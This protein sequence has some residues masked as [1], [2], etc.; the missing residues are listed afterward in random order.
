MHYSLLLT[1]LTVALASSAVLP[2]PNHTAGEEEE[3][4]SLIQRNCYKDGE[5]WGAEYYYALDRAKELCNGPF[6][7]TFR[8]GE[9]RAK[10]FNLSDKKKADFS[11]VHISAGDRQIKY[12][13]CIDGL[14]KEIGRCEHG[15]KTSYVNWEYRCVVVVVVVCNIVLIIKTNVWSFSEPTPIPASAPRYIQS[16]ST[17]PCCVVGYKREIDLFVDFSIPM[18]TITIV[19][20]DGSIYPK[21]IA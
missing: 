19:E 9:Y 4:A 12:A 6:I 18:S 11:L 15:G 10:C 8:G 21:Y 14:Q 20:S 17:T 5:K 1:T 3:D 13:E 2:D 7:G 16:M